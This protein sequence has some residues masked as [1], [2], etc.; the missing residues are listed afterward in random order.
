MSFLTAGMYLIPFRQQF[1]L[2]I[3]IQNIT[4][5]ACIETPT[6]YQFHRVQLHPGF[7][8]CVN[9]VNMRRGVIVG[10]D[11][12]PVA[13]LGK[14]SWRHTFSLTRIK[15]QENEVTYETVNI[16]LFARIARAPTER[17]IRAIWTL[18]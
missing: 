4:D 12:N 1:R 18:G 8:V 3:H 2:M 9:H 5:L 16:G 13:M 10:I 11:H 7:S 15:P 17:E 14:H 6:V